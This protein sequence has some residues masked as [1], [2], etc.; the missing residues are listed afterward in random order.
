MVEAI[1]LGIGHD[2]ES[3][4]AAGLAADVLDAV[5]LVAHPGVVIGLHTEVECHP[6]NAAECAAQ[7]RH[8]L[9][10]GAEGGHE[11][12]VRFVAGEKLADGSFTAPDGAG[13][14]LEVIGRHAEVG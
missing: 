5:G 7:F 12:V 9:L 11:F 2:P 1:L 4:R 6:A 14:R 3:N 10:D 13:D 8:A